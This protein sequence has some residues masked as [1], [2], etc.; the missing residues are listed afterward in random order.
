MQRFFINFGLLGQ[1][2]FFGRW[3]ARLE[4]PPDVAHP[5]LVLVGQKKAPRNRRAF[6]TKQKRFT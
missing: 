4:I 6:F 5:K 2:V 1:G 3:P